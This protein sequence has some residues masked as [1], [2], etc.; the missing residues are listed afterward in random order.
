MTKT[1]GFLD[2]GAISEAMIVG[3]MRSGGND[4]RMVV[5]PRNAAVA[6]R[7][8]KRFPDAV[9]VAPDNQSVLDASDVVVIAVR[10]QVVA[11]IVPS[12]S[13]R[14][15]HLVVSLVA[16]VPIGR[17]EPWVAPATRV[18]RAIPPALVG[19][20]QLVDR[21]HAPPDPIA[22]ELFDRMGSMIEV[23]D[24]S[25]FDAFAAM[26]SVMS[27]HF[28]FAL[29][30][31]EWV[32]AN[33]VEEANASAAVAR[34]LFGL[35]PT[36][37]AELGSSFGRLAEEHTTAGGLNEQFCKHLEGKGVFEAI[38]SGLDDLLVRI[39]GIR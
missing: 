3:L 16:T 14:P 24:E 10:S 37:M 9:S 12:L 35:A 32:A 18:L 11:D 23:A 31:V 22:R 29:E 36:A 6:S 39:T 8:A 25:A 26:T 1:I 34:I 33:G 17:L 4:E 13:F 15:D 27:A 2:T 5:S 28:A 21:P 38:G 7:L 20:G 30:I 19:H